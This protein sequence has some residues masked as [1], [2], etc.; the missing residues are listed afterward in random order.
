MPAPMM[1]TFCG[2]A[3]VAGMETSEAYGWDSIVPQTAAPGLVLYIQL[4]IICLCA[5]TNIR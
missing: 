3:G 5:T 2:R 4:T 1:A